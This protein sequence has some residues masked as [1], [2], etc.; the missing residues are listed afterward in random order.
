M[1][2]NE[3]PCIHCERKGCGAYHDIC[4]EYNDWKKAGREQ[5]EIA[6]KGKKRIYIRSNKEWI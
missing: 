6:K 3:N 5:K 4:K 1:E 2:K